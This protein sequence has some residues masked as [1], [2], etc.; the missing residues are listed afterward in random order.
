MFDKVMPLA[1]SIKSYISTNL[2]AASSSQYGVVRALAKVC[3]LRGAI[4]T[5]LALAALYS[6]SQG[7]S[8]CLIGYEESKE[9]EINGDKTYAKV[10]KGFTLPH[11]VVGTALAVTAIAVAV[12]PALF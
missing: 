6:F 4:V 8:P 3:T 9:V 12:L 11:Y 1:S 7:K 5:A 2:A 10:Q